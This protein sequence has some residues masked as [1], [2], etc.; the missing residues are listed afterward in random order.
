MVV[1]LRIGIDLI[2]RTLIVSVKIIEQGRMHIGMVERGVK[3]SPV[4]NVRLQEELK[5]IFWVEVSVSGIRTG[6]PAGIM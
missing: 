1:K 6:R 3:N 4:R 2:V 5:G